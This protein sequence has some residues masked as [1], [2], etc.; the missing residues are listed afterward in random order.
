MDALARQV[1]LHLK[2]SRR[3]V[4]KP[5]ELY[6]LE[7]AGDDTIVRRRGRQTLRDVRTLGEMMV[8]LERLR[9]H[10]IHDKFAVNLHRVREIRPQ[11]DGEDWEVVMR[12][13]VNR[14]LPV[15]R[16][17]LRSLWRRFGE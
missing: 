9:F 6:Y 10:R 1:L 3:L 2:L 7:A 16:R 17:R 15:S 5:E 11:R 8:V 12:S 4:V 14:V 13:P